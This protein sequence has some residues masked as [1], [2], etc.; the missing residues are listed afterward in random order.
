MEHRNAKPEQPPIR[1]LAVE[2]RCCQ[3]ITASN[4]SPAYFSGESI[5]QAKH[6]PDVGLELRA[7]L[8]CRR[9]ISARLHRADTPWMASRVS[10]SVTIHQRQQALERVVRCHASNGSPSNNF[11][12]LDST[13]PGTRMTMPKTAPS[14]TGQHAGL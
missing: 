10:D 2:Q 3:P 1:T 13:K 11:T 4:T 9:A 12:Y 7:L 6:P 5:Q 14:K 8:L